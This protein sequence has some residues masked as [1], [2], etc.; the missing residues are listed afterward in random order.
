MS[1]NVQLLLARV[2]LSIM[3][4]LSGWGKFGSVEGT[5]GYI[6]SLALPLP[7][8]AAWLT[9]ALEIFGGLAILIGFMTRPAAWALA[10]FCVAT[11]FLAH[12]QPADQMQMISFMKNIAIAGGFL[13]LAAAGPGTWSVDARRTA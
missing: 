9:I 13:A 12:Y 7:A 5:T 1:V 6:A 8:L 2:L 11:A 3:F 4:I 10:A